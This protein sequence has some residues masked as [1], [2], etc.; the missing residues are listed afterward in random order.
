MTDYRGARGSNTGDDFH[1]LWVTRQAI[2][3]LGG[4]DGLEA[5]TVEGVLEGGA[6][7]TWDGVD[8]ALY[9]GGPDARSAN[10][11]R[12]E[13]L[14]YSGSFPTAPWTVS[15]LIQTKKGSGDKSGRGSVIARL[16]KAWKAMRELRPGSSPPEVAIV[17][18]QPIAREVTEA[19]ARVV[20]APVRV[21]KGAAKNGELDE[22]KLARASGLNSEEFRS[23]AKSLD[24]VSKTGS[25]FALEDRVLQA[26]AAWTDQ[27][28]R[29]VSLQLRQFVRERMLPEHD[30]VPI[31][32]EAVQLH[33]LGVSDRHALFPCP[34]DVENPDR[35]IRRLTVEHV[36]RRVAAHA[37]VC[38]HGEGGVG[39]TT[40]LRQIEKDLPPGSCMVAFDCY[41]GGRYLDPS[42]L[43][44]RPMDA[45]VQ[46]TNEVATRLHLPLLLS[47]HGATDFP[48]TFMHRLRQGAETLAAVDPDAL[49]V[50]VIDAA[51]N[52]VTAATE[53]CP[54]E[55]SFVHDFVLL[56]DLPKNVRFVITARTGRLE[57]LRLPERYECLPLQPFDRSETAT[58]VGLHRAAPDEWINEFHDLSNGVPRVQAYA[59]KGEQDGPDG[60]LERLRP[61]KSLGDVF[62]ERFVEAL[63]KTGNT[64]EV[65][66]LCAGLVSLARPVPLAALAAVLGLGPAHVRDICSDL[67]PGIRLQGDTVRFADEDFEAFVRDRAGSELKAVQD[68]AATWLLSRS[69]DDQYAAIHVA[70][71]LS[72]AERFEELLA[73]VEEEPV[74]AAVADAIQRRESE[75]QRLRL[76]LSASR[77]AGSDSRALRYV[78]LGAEGIRTDDTLRDLLAENPDLAVRFAT[79]TIGRLILSDPGQRP[80]HGRL[81]F[82]QLVVHAERG[83]PISFR[84]GM[85]SLAA[86]LDARKAA[87][88]DANGA[89][90]KQWPLDIRAVEADV[91]AAFKLEGP[92]AAISRMEG[93]RPRAVH[94][95]IG[96]DLPGRLIAEGKAPA[97]EELL[98]DGG[99]GPTGGVF[100]RV[101]LALA[102]RKVDADLL[103][104]GLLRLSR[105][106]R[107]SQFMKG[108]QGDDALGTRLVDLLLTGCEVL[109]VLDP[110]R[111]RIDVILERFL[112]PQLR[113]IDRHYPSDPVRLDAL[114]RAHAL[115]EARAGRLPLASDLFEPRPLEDP[116]PDT[117]KRRSG[118][119]EADRDRELQEHANVFFAIYGVVARALVGTLSGG[120][121]VVELRRASTSIR[122]KAWRLRR[123]PASGGARVLAAR[124]VLSLLTTGLEPTPLLETAFDLDGDWRSGH[125]SPDTRMVSRLSL[126]PELHE[127]LAAALTTA[128]GETSRLRI[129][130]REKAGILVQYSRSLLPLS[131]DD[132]GGVFRL[133]VEAAGELDSEVNA[134]LIMLEQLVR[135]AADVTPDRRGTALAL[136]EIVL[137]AAIR[138]D[139]DDHFP[140]DRAMAALARLDP[141]LALAAASRWD[142]RGMVELRHS[143]PEVLRSSLETGSTTPGQ[144]AAL[145]LIL[146]FDD[147]VLSASMSCARARNVRNLDALW[148]EAARDLLL[149]P[150]RE[151]SPS[152]LLATATVSTGSMV[153][154][155]LAQEEFERATNCAALPVEESPDRSV[156]TDIV[157]LHRW[158]PSDLLDA[159]ALIS[160]TSR[161]QESA[162]EKR[163]YLSR[164][165]ILVAARTAVPLRDRSRHLDALVSGGHVG[166]GKVPI[167]ALLSALD[168]W[169]SPGVDAWS[170]S[171]LPG[172][173][174]EWLPRITL[175][176][177]YGQDELTPLLS[178]AGLSAEGQRDLLLGSIQENVEALSAEGIFG[179]VAR[180]GALLA[181]EDAADLLEWYVARLSS[182]IDQEHLEAIGPPSDLPT[183]M[184]ESVGRTIVAR[185]ASP[186]TRIRWRAAHALRRLARTGDTSVVPAV[187]ARYGKQD[188][189]VFSGPMP[190]YYPLAARLWSVIAL[191]RVAGE[192]PSAAA[193]AGRLLLNTALDDAFP[194]LLLRAFARDAC[195]KLIV[196]GALSPTPAQVTALAAVN[197]PGVPRIKV[198]DRHRAFG[199]EAEC[200]ERRFGFDSMDTLPYW[201]ERILRAFAGLNGQRFLDEAERWIVD[202]WGWNEEKVQAAPRLRWRF[203]RE[204]DYGLTSHRQGSNPVIEPLDTHLEWH[205]MWCA[206]GELL[207]T[208]PLVECDPDD[209]DDLGGRIAREQLSE[210][211][212]WSADL[213]DPTP[214]HARFRSLG[215]LSLPEW[216]EA[217]SE[218]DHRIPMLPPERTDYVAVDGHEETTAGD[219]SHRSRLSSAL[220]DP[221]TGS[222]LLRALQTVDDSWDYRLPDEGDSDFEFDDPPLRLL[223][224]LRSP[225]R[226]EGIDG[227]DPYKGYARRLETL[228]GERVR[229]ACGLL[230]DDAGAPRW[231][232]AASPVPMFIH[233]T[234]GEGERDDDGS[235]TRS[236]GQ[237]LLVHREQLADF[238]RA[239]G[240]DLV[241]EVEVTRSGRQARRYSSEEETPPP[242]AKFD[243]L[244]R[245]D[246]SGGLHVAEG[247]LGTWT[248]AGTKSRST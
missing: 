17:T 209:W 121:A 37:Y 44:H 122:N 117:Q 236:V 97:V 153:Q 151:G 47:R 34:S 203:G 74:P 124:Q 85:R 178:H 223:G 147:G 229:R 146:E 241:I 170:R 214:L 102:G 64:R 174:S 175:G 113:R 158:T 53:R 87:L 180:V 123:E 91:E 119:F 90:R 157:A 51:D 245:L 244:Y 59:F 63:A 31:T 190:A 28:A 35:R 104:R 39:K 112:K 198:K 66:G 42:A 159:P 24:L 177:P 111:I 33:A 143:L 19:M 168:A 176:M 207:K 26:M 99:L 237:R 10:R 167:R 231:W 21:P 172:L 32:R 222:S 216:T 103:D 93:W 108:H 220:V 23:F 15:R 40:A 18:N 138:L 166:W 43:R 109:T 141:P 185:M 233:E 164:D 208:V 78:L 213:L 58:F 98:G 57:S 181:E 106:V 197:T 139:G 227:H 194:H 161:L 67:A 46:L 12:L 60:A 76:A 83:D 246:A 140:W 160:T 133:A 2:G 69:R 235:R 127:A 226:D 144:A 107:V 135:Q 38:I 14:K 8:C 179:L 3:L 156:Q 238:L 62:E 68:R 27:D 240:L 1:E 126:R 125:R 219:R 77:A 89:P 242:E 217:V 218:V 221:S 224:W 200:R 118:G 48:R 150:G 131:P 205:A 215:D 81:L 184:D 142:A 191:D 173:I 75:V 50:V 155:A 186:D 154:A 149:R 129:G 4:D 73:L 130:A 22:V 114:F 72:A 45:F 196:A 204:Q 61:G 13:Q 110:A 96:L 116:K 137:D 88:P 199:F 132:A 188:D 95:E 247:R 128:A 11:V 162:R 5:L 29:T 145:G 49:L 234:W 193:H 239:E 30:R 210:P 171:R 25:R 9:F 189:A 36:S 165:E 248:G 94:V 195:H 169:R 20:A 86:W 105:M 187:V 84:N 230:R 65:A 182:R 80:N 70:P 6:P 100:V 71:A 54:P 56:Q 136:G 101:P 183:S 212:L 92:S 201:Y 202:V 134:Q 211:P 52:S 206:A 16:A 7:D 115:R 148:E 82:H 41:G 163:I 152:D 232:R 120:D 55:T 192:T 225:Q 243:R 228:P 79:N